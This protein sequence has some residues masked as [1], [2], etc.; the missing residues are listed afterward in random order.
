LFFF[1]LSNS[2]FFLFVGCRHG[3]Q[4]PRFEGG[5][6]LAA[7]PGEDLIYLDQD[8]AEIVRLAVDVLPEDDDP[9]PIPK[10]NRRPGI[11]LPAG[12]ASSRQASA[13]SQRTWSSSFAFAR[14]TRS[15][16]DHIS[17]MMILSS[18][19]EPVRQIAEMKMLLETADM[20]RI[21]MR[22]SE[23]RLR[24]ACVIVPIKL[25]SELLHDVGRIIVFVVGGFGDIDVS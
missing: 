11:S 21:R 13:S 23:R 24:T 1:W 7:D 10:G 14:R 5:I 2:V 3:R 19:L 4:Q 25:L 16:T 9:V 6:R 12:R 20:V 17:R 22:C 8:I 18:P 15:E